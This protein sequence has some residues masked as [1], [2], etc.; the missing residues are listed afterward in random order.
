VTLAQAEQLSEHGAPF[1]ERE[2]QVV[3]PVVGRM[4]VEEDAADVGDR[5]GVRAEG[6]QLVLVAPVDGEVDE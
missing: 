2:K 1:V 5:I 4:E 3:V 6:L